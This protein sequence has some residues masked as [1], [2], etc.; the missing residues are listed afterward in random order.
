M[1]LKPIRILTVGRV[2]APFW[3]DAIEYYRER[4]IRWRTLTETCVRDSDPSF[5]IQDRI[6]Q[7]SRAILAALT[8]YDIPICLDEHGMSL[9]SRQFAAFL[10][11]LSSNANRIPCFIIGGPYGYNESVLKAAYKTI[12]FGS[13]TLPHELARVILFEQLY[14]AEAI[15]RNIPY[16]HE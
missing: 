7:E 13:I 10:A 6:T 3:K 5:S 9:T 15:L 12:A 16:H 8:P 14:R 11:K 2:K 4:L 1:V